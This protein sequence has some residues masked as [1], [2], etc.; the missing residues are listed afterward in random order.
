MV[1]IGNVAMDVTRILAQDPEK[2][3][4]TDIADYALE[5]LRKSRIK[6]VYLLGRRGP[7]QAAYSPAEI[8]ELGELESADLE[9]KP[10]ELVLDEVSKAQCSDAAVR[11]NV[12]Y[13]VEAAKRPIGKK[14]RR[15]VL[16]FSVSPTEV[17]GEGG[18]VSGLTL[19]KNDLIPDG[20]GSVKAKGSGKFEKIST[21]LVFRS[22]GYRGIAIPG[23]SFDEKAGKI[24]NAEGR[25][26][27]GGQKVLQGEYVVGWAKRGP[28][29]LIGTNRADSVLTVN[30][31]LADAKAEKFLAPKDRSPE[32]IPALLKGRGVRFISFADWKAIDKAE[33]ENGKARGKIRSKFSNVEDMLKAVNG[34]VPAAR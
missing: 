26:L 19:E 14:G 18:K 28:S 30:A 15:V 2:L 29:G 3:A 33:L 21:G 34:A 16:R 24:P 31:V 5:A 27:D 1:G 8:A 4:G 22:V 7:A 23:V 32:S 11:K 9:L 20:R 6:T 13:V 25:V 12:D 10:E 17:L